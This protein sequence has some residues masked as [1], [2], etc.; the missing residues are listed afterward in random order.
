MCEP[1][2][3]I[4]APKML[5]YL[6][7]LHVQLQSRRVYG[8]DGCRLFGKC[9]NYMA[10]YIERLP[11][12]TE[13]KAHKLLRLCERNGLSSQCKLCIC[14]TSPST[15]LHYNHRQQYSIP[16]IPC[17]FRGPSLVSLQNNPT[18]FPGRVS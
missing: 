2:F 3:G 14:A 12:E 11:I 5:S 8:V 15:Y 1:K 13:Q 9:R 7:H 17:G 18:S 6:A 16:C 4:T 10:E